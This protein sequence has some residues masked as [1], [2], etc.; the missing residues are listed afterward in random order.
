M[1]VPIWELTRSAGLTSYF[2]LFLSV[3]AGLILSM[4]INLKLNK[5]LQVIHQ[6]AGWY[7]LLIGLFHI[8]LLNINTHHPYTLTEIL[9]PFTAKEHAILNGI[10]TISL[11]VMVILFLSGDLIT[12]I[13]AKVWKKI[14]RLALPSY[15]LISIHGIFIGTD[16]KE[17]WV[18]ILYTSSLAVIFSLLIVKLLKLKSTQ[19]EKFSI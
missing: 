9:I 4:K 6:S 5:H 11:Y 1:V 17:E 18:M 7:S 15:I 13:G 8:L 12:N 10:G 3:A 2:L 16:T 19:K 14:H